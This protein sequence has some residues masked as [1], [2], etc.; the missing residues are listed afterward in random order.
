MTKYLENPS[1]DVEGQVGPGVAHVGGIVHSGP[2]VVP[3]YLCMCAGVWVWRGAGER[4]CRCVGV[5]VCRCAGV[6]V[7]RCA[8]VQVPTFLPFCGTNISFSLVREL[9]SLRVG[10]WSCGLGASHWGCT[11]LAPELILACFLL[12]WLL[13]GLLEDTEKV[14]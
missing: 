13:A 5:H 4:V 2:A 3:G 10:P 8:G 12:R 6:Q 9:K 1:E 7:C 14:L 11:L